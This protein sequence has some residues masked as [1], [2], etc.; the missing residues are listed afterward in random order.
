[1]KA[2]PV[3]IVSVCGQIVA[4]LGGRGAKT[5]IASIS[6]LVYQRFIYGINYGVPTVIISG[7]GVKLNPLRCL[8]IQ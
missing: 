5:G 2:L 8:R 6:W 4:R 1:V 3:I 7:L